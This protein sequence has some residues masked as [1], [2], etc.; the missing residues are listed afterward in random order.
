MAVPWS[1]SRP[2]SR[3]GRWEGRIIRESVSE[4]QYRAASPPA[5]ADRRADRPRPAWI[6]SVNR[7]WRRSRPGKDA[8]ARANALRDEKRWPEAADAYGAALAAH[9]EAAELWIQRGHALKEAGRLDAAAESYRRGTDAAPG[10]RDPWLHLAHLEKRRG[11]RAEA[12][13]A[14]AR[15]AALDP[16]DPEPARELVALGA[17][18]AEAADTAL[19]GLAALAAEIRAIRDALER[20][21]R[22]LPDLT[23]IAC[24]PPELYDLVRRRW[25]LAPPPG[26]DGRDARILVLVDAEGASAMDARATVDSLH[27]QRRGSW[28]AVLCG[29]SEE[30]AA[31]A[32]QLTPPGG[33]VTRTPTPAAESDADIVVC[34]RAGF[35]LAPEALAWIAAAAARLRFAAA[36][37]DV[38]RRAKD[39]ALR[40]ELRSAFDLDLLLHEGAPPLAAFDAAL[41][42][43]AGEESPAGSGL[44]RRVVATFLAAWRRDRPIASIPRMLGTAPAIPP[45]PPAAMALPGFGEARPAPLPLPEDEGAVALAWTAPAPARRI[46]AVIPTRDRLDLLRPCLE[47]L[48]AEAARP[49][50]LDV[51]VVDHASAEPET[52]GFLAEGARDGRFRTIR[53]E[54][55]FNWSRLSNLGAAHADGGLLLFLNNDTAMLTPGW[56]DILRGFLQRPDAGAVGARLIYPGRRIQ[57]AGMSFS[58]DRIEHEG[59]FADLR[60]GGPGERYRRSHAVSAVTGAF[61]GVSAETFEACGRFPEDRF[62]NDLSDVDFCLRVRESGRL[63]LYTPLITLLHHESETRG[64]ISAAEAAWERA[65]LAA[66]RQRWGSALSLDPGANP[67]W[68]PSGQLFRALCP[69]SEAQVWRWLA[70]TAPPTRWRPAHA[71]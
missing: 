1:V 32:S 41:W 21:E 46:T 13:R 16:A 54:G 51:L 43:E 66:F 8:V 45:A 62:P 22:R 30:T 69:P 3:H 48:C 4:S 35:A 50:L 12:M 5:Q 59:R 34:C 49:D 31:H 65:D 17:E 9:P 58:D 47:T 57:H 70:A 44:G 61:L 25:D 33:P 71:P 42:R 28:R 6:A 14:F 23:A 15:V 27:G 36:A 20:C 26:A 56:D 2:G 52:L 63:V 60:D 55:P 39:G 37:A 10:S 24:P 67:L 38:D 11:Q 68:A 64:R 53:D 7:L 19:I 29:E 18:A 40:P